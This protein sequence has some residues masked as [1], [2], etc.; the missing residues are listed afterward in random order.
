MYKKIVVPVDL[1]HPEL[2]DKA[3]ATAA[4]LAKHYGASL[5]LIAV[6][7]TIPGAVAHNPR[8][9]SEKLTQYATRKSNDHGLNINSTVA[10]ANDPAVDLDKTLDK[11]F[12]EA[13]AD[14]VVMASHVP[15]FRDYV[16]A[17]NAGFLASHSDLTV[18]V[19]R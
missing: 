11:A 14:L 17:S 5:T 19:V 15:G 16:F 12:H 10:I 9:F 7:S 8:E 6:T 4:D 13:N 3:I 2:L 1:T 18:M